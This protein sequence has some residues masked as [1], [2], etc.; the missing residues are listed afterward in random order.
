MS[1]AR[2]PQGIPVGG[3]F[4]GLIHAEPGG[5]VTQVRT[6]P[7]PVFTAED[8]A[9]TKY[10]RL[11]A[12]SEDRLVDL[13]RTPIR[14]YLEMKHAKEWHADT[15]R[16]YARVV[17]NPAAKNEAWHQQHPYAPAWAHPNDFQITDIYKELRTF[18]VVADSRGFDLRQYSPGLNAAR[19]GLHHSQLDVSDRTT[20]TNYFS[21]HEWNDCKDHS[22]PDST[23]WDIQDRLHLITEKIPRMDKPV[24]VWRGEHYNTEAKA[25]DAARI[26]DRIGYLLDLK[27][28]DAF[29]WDNCAATSLSLQTAAMQFSE[30]SAPEEFSSLDRYRANEDVSHSVLFELETDRGVYIDEDLTKK[31]NSNENEILIPGCTEFAV[32]GH[33]QLGAQD[34]KKKGGGSAY[35]LIKLRLRSA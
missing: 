5:L 11:L 9:E 10:G 19:E 1:T 35:H 29:E 13:G 34:V 30:S 21:K 15:L 7:G 3:R 4:A 31:N 14:N 27:P 28:G 18:D 26:R 8:L 33:Y 22:Q 32:L 24:T 2:Q 23:Y 16:N 25:G 17:G 20:L 6:H 12:E